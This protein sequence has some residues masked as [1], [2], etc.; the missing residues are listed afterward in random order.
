MDWNTTGAPARTGR[1]RATRADAAARC[2][3]PHRAPAWGARRSVARIERARPAHLR[4]G[5][6][7]ARGAPRR[8]F[9]QARGAQGSRGGGGPAF[10]AAWRQA[11]PHRAARYGEPLGLVLVDRW[12]QFLLA[13]DLGA[14]VRARLSRRA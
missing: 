11:P 3:S 14:A 8:R 10:Q 6:A 1:V 7:A 9:P 2:R 4:F 13:P 5:R 12:A